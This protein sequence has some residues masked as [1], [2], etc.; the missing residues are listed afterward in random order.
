M[1]RNEITKE[2]GDRLKPKDCHAP[3]LSGL[4]KI[5]KEDV[6]MRGIVSTVGSPFEKLSR[7]LVAT[8][9]IEL[10]KFSIKCI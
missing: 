3:R 10:V 1:K 2:E 4:P 6:P 9:L 5:H 7:Y 8:I